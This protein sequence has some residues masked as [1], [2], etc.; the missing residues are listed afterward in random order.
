MV[1]ARGTKTRGSYRG[2]FSD[3]PFSHIDRE[4]ILGRNKFG[5]HHEDLP[6]STNPR[7]H[8]RAGPTNRKLQ[9]RCAIARKSGKTRRETSAK[10]VSFGMAAREYLSDDVDAIGTLCL[11]DAERTWPPEPRAITG[12]RL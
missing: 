11:L 3:Q 1:D 6:D 5:L 9:L 12:H 7:I 8:H 4:G 2:P 10:K